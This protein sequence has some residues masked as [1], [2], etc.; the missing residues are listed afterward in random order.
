LRGQNAFWLK[1]SN[2]T[3]GGTGSGSQAEASYGWDATA[4][5]NNFIVVYPDGLNG[6]WNAGLCCGS[7]A[8]NNVNDVQF[9]ADLLTDLQ[10][11]LCQDSSRVFSTGHSNGAMMSHRL[12]C[13]LSNRI[14]AIASSAGSLMVTSGACNPARKIPV[15]EMHSM[16]DYNVPWNG[17]PGKTLIISVILPLRC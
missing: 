7:S 4:Q 5:A 2:F 13:E 6:V 16:D 9:I 8:L 14:T 12:A 11:K 17:G 10:G 1:M 3:I 15:M